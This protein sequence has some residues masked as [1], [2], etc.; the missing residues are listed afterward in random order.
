MLLRLI[1]NTAIRIQCQGGQGQ[2]KLRTSVDIPRR[3]YSKGFPNRSRLKKSCKNLKR[4]L[5]IV[6]IYRNEISR[7]LGGS[8]VEKMN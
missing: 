6:V 2:K 5:A 4:T 8:Q 3:P 7:E 1:C